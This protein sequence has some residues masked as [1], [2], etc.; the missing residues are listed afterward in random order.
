MTLSDILFIFMH[1]HFIVHR[2][3]NKVIL[4]KKTIQQG[5]AEIMTINDNL[6][7]PVSIRTGSN[8][9]LTNLTK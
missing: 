3:S 2:L 6:Y 8:E 1:S 4:I 7:P 9:I 5:N